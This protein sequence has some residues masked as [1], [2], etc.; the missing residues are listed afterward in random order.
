M[1]VHDADGEIA[2][3][4]SVTAALLERIIA[5]QSCE[6]EVIL[7]GM[8]RV[9]YETTTGGV[10]TRPVEHVLH[11]PGILDTERLARPIPVGVLLPEVHTIGR[12]DVLDPS[13]LLTDVYRFHSRHPTFLVIV[14]SVRCRR[15]DTQIHDQPD[16][17]DPMGE[18]APSGYK[19]L[20]PAGGEVRSREE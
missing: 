12:R 7:D 15:S 3:R 4:P 8:L 1:Y 18:N 2:R 9:Q 16:I 19:L 14:D 11:V 10:G 5:D 20:N 6:L 13:G 17:D